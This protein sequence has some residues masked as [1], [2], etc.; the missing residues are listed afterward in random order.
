MATLG[1]WLVTA[2]S[3]AHAEYLVRSRAEQRGIQLI[4]LTVS[5][6]AGE[7]WQVTATVADAEQDHANAARLGEDTQ[8][9]HL[10]T[11][12]RPPVR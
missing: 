1:P 12:P 11:H 6:G 5:D 9:L 10:D 7:M 3:Q 4:D 2:R 8:V